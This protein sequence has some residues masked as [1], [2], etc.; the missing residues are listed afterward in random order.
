MGDSQSNQKE[1]LERVAVR[2][3]TYLRKRVAELEG[4]E[5]TLREQLS[6][7]KEMA[8]KVAEAVE[9]LPPLPIKGSKVFGPPPNS[10]RSETP[11]PLFLKL[12]DWHIGEYIRAEETEGF[13]GYSWDIAQQR[14]HTITDNLIESVRSSRS[15][16][17]IEELVV[18]AEGDFVS[19][20]IHDELKVTNEFPLPVQAAKAGALL[21]EVIYKL[22]GHFKKVRVLEIGADNHGRMTKKPQAKQ[23]SL[24]NANFMVYAVAN[25]SLENVRKQNVEIIQPEGIKA[26]IRVAGWDFLV[27]HGDE[28]KAWMGIPYYG[29]ERTRAREAVKRMNADGYRFH[30]Q[31]IGHWHVAGIVSGNI[32][33]N[34]SLSGTSEYDHAQGRQAAPAQVSFLVHPKYGIFNWTAWRA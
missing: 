16:F 9:A 26:V 23:K 4:I 25:A 28:T 22:S 21:R 3:E 27:E 24:N 32:L 20:D 14:A 11:I 29:L 34:G 30:Y 1:L 33:V 15:L 6:S 17:N 7:R 19:G 10:N 2:Q 8:A 31:S 12:S 13:G 18:S 5:A